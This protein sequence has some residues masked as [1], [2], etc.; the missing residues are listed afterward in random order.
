MPL[1]WDQKNLCVNVN[2]IGID[3]GVYGALQALK[4]REFQII[5]SRPLKCLESLEN[6]PFWKPLRNFFQK[7]PRSHSVEGF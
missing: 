7:Q 1:G 3:K 6:E 4:S 5:F 2:H